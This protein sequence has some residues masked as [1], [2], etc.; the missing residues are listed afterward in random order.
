VNLTTG[1]DIT[2]FCDK[3]SAYTADRNWALANCGGMAAAWDTDNYEPEWRIWVA[4]RPGVLDDRTLRTFAAWCAQQVWHLVGDPRS[5]NATEVAR[6]HAVGGATDE[7]LTAAHTAAEAAE[8]V[9]RSPVGQDTPAATW[10]ARAATYAATP[11]GTWAA[12]GGAARAAAEAAAYAATRAAARAA[13]E[14]VFLDAAEA[15]A[16]FVAKST[17]AKWLRENVRNPFNAVPALS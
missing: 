13:A 10:A 16:A 11:A 17:Q 1:Q 8:I 2:A 12:T 5:R 4:T 6:R 15:A 14:A 3:Y 7:E 9:M